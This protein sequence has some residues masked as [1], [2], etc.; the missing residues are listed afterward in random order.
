MI[1]SRREA[2]LKLYGYNSRRVGFIVHRKARIRVGQCTFTRT[3]LLIST[4]GNS[5]L[6]PRI[7]QVGNRFQGPH[8]SSSF[9]R[10]H[11]LLGIPLHYRLLKLEFFPERD[12]MSSPWI[13]IIIHA[14][15]RQFWIIVYLY[16]CFICIS[17]N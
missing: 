11:H 14:C 4:K 17:S 2:S 8:C 1:P 12:L 15:I 6:I 10:F 16:R 5:S 3:L 9:P 7:Y 13:R